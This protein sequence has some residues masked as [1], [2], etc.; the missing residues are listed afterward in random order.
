MLKNY[1]S[2]SCMFLEY[3]LLFQS[4]IRFSNLCCP[5]TSYTPMIYRGKHVTETVFFM[6]AEVGLIAD[7]HQNENSIFFPQKIMRQT[8]L[9]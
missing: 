5:R 4:K 9:P 7:I 2:K 6:V 3:R 1:G 8:L